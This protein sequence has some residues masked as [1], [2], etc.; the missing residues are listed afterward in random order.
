MGVKSPANTAPGR[1]DTPTQLRLTGKA[2]KPAYPSPI[3][4]EEMD[5]L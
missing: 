2:G 1:E 3:K 4:E 5:R